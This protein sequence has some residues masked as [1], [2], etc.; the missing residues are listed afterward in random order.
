MHLQNFQRPIRDACI[1][2]LLSGTCAS[3][4]YRAPLAHA[5]IGC[6]RLV[7]PLESA[8]S[9][10]TNCTIVDK[11]YTTIGQ[12]RVPFV[13]NSSLYGLSWVE[14]V[15]VTDHDDNRR[16]FEKNFYLGT[17]SYM[18]TSGLVGCAI[19]FTAVNRSQANY[20]GAWGETVME[21]PDFIGI[22][23]VDALSEQ[24][25]SVDISGLGTEE[26]CIKVK[27]E[28]SHNLNSACAASSY[29]GRDGWTNL[30]VKGKFIRRGRIWL[31]PT[32]T[33]PC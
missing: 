3:W 5:V 21:C 31:L 14:G 23:C 27:D 30:T 1:M 24:A 17:P 16:T 8:N 28:I 26:A 4:E 15:A 29:V 12:G 10:T 22:D 19:F 9:T 20:G 18:D 25:R 13:S 7:C 11:T 32:F 33:F 2:A 6:E